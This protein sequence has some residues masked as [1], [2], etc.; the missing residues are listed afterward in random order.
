MELKLVATQTPYKAT[1]SL[2]NEGRAL[3]YTASV[4]RQSDGSAQVT[5]NLPEGQKQEFASAKH[6][7]KFTL[8]GNKGDMEIDFKNPEGKTTF[9]S[10]VDYRVKPWGAFVAVPWATAKAGGTDYYNSGAQKATS[11]CSIFGSKVS[12]Q[13]QIFDDSG[14]LKF[15]VTDE[16]KNVSSNSLYKYVRESSLRY[17]TPEGKDLG[18]VNV[19]TRVYPDGKRIG[20]DVRAA[21]PK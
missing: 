13:T 5:F 15:L 1:E 9:H 21:P 17:Q 2:L 8:F 3:A 10:T 12:C 14:K 16:S 4:L 6:L 7:P 18:T 11:S 20:V 19:T